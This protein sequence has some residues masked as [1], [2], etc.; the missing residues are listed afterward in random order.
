MYQEATLLQGYVQMQSARDPSGAKGM[1]AR[2]WRDARLQGQLGQALALL[3]GKSRRLLD[4]SALRKAS[5]LVGGY[6][7]GLRTVA[8]SK[9][10]GS[11]GRSEDFD[12]EFHPLKLHN[13]GR[14]LG[15]AAARQRGV[16]LPPVDL[17]QIGGIYF[18]RDGH[19]RISVAKAFGQDEIEADVTVLETA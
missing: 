2:K 18:V 7:I 9:I 11:E 19:H 3:T 10:R 4:L 6:S 5:S 13:Q 16:V 17:I 1:A 14:W 8:I 12:Q 15:V